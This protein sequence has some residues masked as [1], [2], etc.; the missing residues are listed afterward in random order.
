MREVPTRVDNGDDNGC[1]S[2]GD[3]PRGKCFDQTQVVLL[4][5]GWIV[6]HK[7]VAIRVLR[8]NDFKIAGSVK[9]VD[10]IF[11]VL[12]LIECE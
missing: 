9:L 1:I 7:G 5:D 3:A 10:V 6:G 8:L 11:Y 2:L 4:I 12:V